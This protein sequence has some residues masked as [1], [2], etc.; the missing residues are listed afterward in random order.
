MHER[1]PRGVRGSRE[2]DKGRHSEVGQRRRV[3]NGRAN[4]VWSAGRTVNRGGGGGQPER[5]WGTDL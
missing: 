1:E 4:G 3:V 2:L 5:R